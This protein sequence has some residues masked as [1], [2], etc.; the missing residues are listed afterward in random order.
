[1]N[2]IN[3][4]KVAAFFAS[5]MYSI[6]TMGALSNDVSQQ[7]LVLGAGNVP[8][9]LALVPSVEYPTATSLANTGSFNPKERYYGYFDSR[10]CYALRAEDEV[11]KEEYFEPIKTRLHDSGV[12]TELPLCGN[13]EWH[14]NFLNWAFTSTVDA[15]RAA[16]T[17]GYRHVDTTELTI[18]QKARSPHHNMGDRID[19]SRDSIDYSKYIPN[20]NK[21]YK[22]LDK[23]ILGNNGIQAELV[24]KR[25]A[26]GVLTR[27]KKINVRVQVC[28]SGQ[29][30]Q[31][32]NCV[33]YGSNYKPEGLIQEYSE[34]VRF[35]AF[36]YLNEST[37]DRAGGV[38]RA[39]QKFVGPTVNKAENPYKEWDA[40]T[41]VFYQDPDRKLNEGKS[42]WPTTNNS[43]VINYINKFGELGTGPLKSYDPVSE[44]YYAALRYFTNQGN[45]PNFS[46]K[47]SSANDNDLIKVADYFPVIEKW[48]DPITSQYSCQKNAILGIGDTNTHN[49]YRIPLD[50]VP[51]E[52]HSKYT[53]EIFKQEKISKDPF[54]P[55]DGKNNRAHIA[56][57]AYYANTMDI[58][59]DRIGKQTIQ[60]YWVDVRENGHL[61]RRESNQ[62]WLAAKYG[63]FDVPENF[64]P[65]GTNSDAKR[66]VSSAFKDAQ[67]WRDPNE[68]TLESGDYRPR[69]FFVASDAKKMADSL[70]D[71]F[72]AIARAPKANLTAMVNS[73]PREYLSDSLMFDAS[74]DAQYW[75]G[76]LVARKLSDIVDKSKGT[77]FLWSA[78][79]Q[80]AKQGHANRNIYTNLP[81]KQASAVIKGSVAFKWGKLNLAGFTKEHINYL[82]GDSTLELGRGE[83]GKFRQRADL[84]DKKVNILGDIANSKPAYNHALNQ[85]YARLDSRLFSRANEQYENFL[86]QQKTQAPLLAVGAND[87]MLHVFNA[88]TGDELY[89]YIPHTVLD[90]TLKLSEPNYQ[91]QY[92]VDGSPEI[93]H[94][95]DKADNSW[96]TIIVGSTGAGGNSVFAIDATNTNA[97]NEKS[98][99]WEF[100]D[101]DL[102][103][104][105][106]K[107]T[108]LPLANGEFGVVFSS[109]VGRNGTDSGYLF[110]VKASNGE[111]IKKVQIATNGD[112]GE[113]LVAAD[114]NEFI[115]ARQAFVGDSLGN[116]W[117]LDLSSSE[118]SKWNVFNNRPMFVAQTIEG[119]K[120]PIMSA[121]NAAYSH[122][123]NMTIVFGTG[124]LYRNS[125]IEIVQENQ[126]PQTLY[127]IV[128]KKTD[129]GYGFY[130]DTEVRSNLHRFVVK[131]EHKLAGMTGLEIAKVGAPNVEAT[132]YV[133]GSWRFD[134]QAAKSNELSE[135]FL[136]QALIQ[137]GIVSVTSFTPDNNPCGGEGRSAT[138][139]FSLNPNKNYHETLL[140]EG[141]GN[142]RFITGF[143]VGA[144]TGFDAGATVAGHL[145]VY[146]DGRVITLNKVEKPVE[147]NFKPGRLS[148]YEEQEGQD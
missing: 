74:L 145:M 5:F 35:S 113:P 11:A 108:V 100:T 3:N 94:I 4:T 146:R 116:L 18:L 107:P 9:S 147:A 88:N 55:F 39:A 48:S 118:P 122:D 141:L 123:G 75:S 31:E 24:Y 81:S 57:L 56:G 134:T 110:I 90:K 121:L 38:M 70:K 86:T 32:D 23:I 54:N 47:P 106:G 7:P 53:E 49:D 80:L 71:A 120:Q 62:Y 85:G 65:I 61:K 97:L 26:G 83:Q 19:L 126:I 63:G 52:K 50:F 137:D 22:Y 92:Y 128:P 111:L 6:S 43:G 117:H 96:K 51:G 132:S 135:R 44:L 34:N 67:L 14:G 46:K 142:G 99:L 42:S 112:L 138:Y 60:T 76:D 125:D 114:F 30:Q 16:L 37:L 89:A 130:T 129:T 59:P 45:E 36:S 8:G 148:W 41:G 104:F 40:S 105:I 12:G 58:R 82:R 133:K 140:H 136:T 98:L 91:H 25:R 64:S 29:N 20:Y 72:A 33:K 131:A 28:K 102:G 143:L 95:Y 77:S 87:G 13:T 2:I 10:R 21:E 115:I 68:A 84:L 144:D 139:V 101:K 1:M 103:S 73:S 127:G 78:A 109:G 66:L 27:T 124:S 17:G 79:A 119:E 69:N 15:F 93:S